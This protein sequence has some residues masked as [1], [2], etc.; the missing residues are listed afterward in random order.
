MGKTRVYQCPSVVKNPKLQKEPNFRCKTLLINK[1]RIYTPPIKVNQGY[2]NLVK[3]RHVQR[4]LRPSF[5]G[6]RG[7]GS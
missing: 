7:T 3:A 5:L 2:S 1:M 6:C 4:W